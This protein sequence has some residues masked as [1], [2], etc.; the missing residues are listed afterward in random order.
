[1]VS[2]QW[3]TVSGQL[4]GAVADRKTRKIAPM[5]TGLIVFAETKEKRKKGQAL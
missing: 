1:V 5:R 3:S 2:G 4:F